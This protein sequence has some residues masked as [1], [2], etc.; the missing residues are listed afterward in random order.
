MIE[1]KTD[2]IIFYDKKSSLHCTGK[3]K[4]EYLEIA[5]EMAKTKKV[6][7]I[8][9]KAQTYD[10]NKPKGCTISWYNMKNGKPEIIYS[11]MK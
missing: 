4:S 1:I 3:S 11:E 7:R 8:R 6:S 5:E 10:D 2:A 9:I